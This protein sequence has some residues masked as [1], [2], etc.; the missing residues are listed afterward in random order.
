M[1]LQN[2]LC[3]VQIE[4]D[5]TYTVESTDN[6]HY[7]L[8]LNPDCY[9]HNGVYKTLAIHI[10]MY[11]NTLDIALI[12]DFYSYDDDCAVLDGE[13]LTVLQ[14]NTISQIK[15][16]DGSM[17]LHKKFECFGCNFGLYKVPMGYIVYGEM[18]ITMLDLQFNKMWSFLGKDIFVTQSNKTPFKICSNSIQLYDFD[19]NYYE[20][21]FNGNLIA[22]SQN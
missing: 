12:G 18:E 5:S 11:F 10:D 17:V 14:N 6:R 7:D 3:T 9:K 1:K 20:L 22:E 16:T 19:D 21:D 8:V 2:E 4:I 15:I 13:I